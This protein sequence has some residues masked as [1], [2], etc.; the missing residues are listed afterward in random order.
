MTQHLTSVHS[1]H[2]AVKAAVGGVLGSQHIP[3]R[4]STCCP[5][6]CVREAYYGVQLP[7]DTACLTY[8]QVCCLQS[9]AYCRTTH[10]STGCVDSAVLLL[11]LLLLCR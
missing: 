8:S 3:L 11:P 6:V 4:G 9:C 2:S 7:S 5:H 1:L 10:A